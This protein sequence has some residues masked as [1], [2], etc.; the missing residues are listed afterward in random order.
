MEIWNLSHSKFICLL[1]LIVAFVR[2][3]GI[4]LVGHLRLAHS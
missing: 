3:N 1:A 2:C 4:G